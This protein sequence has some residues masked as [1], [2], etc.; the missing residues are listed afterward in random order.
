MKPSVHTFGD[1]KVTRAYICHESYPKHP[2]CYIMWD[3]EYYGNKMRV[4]ND[5]VNMEFWDSIT[6]DNIIAKNELVSITPEFV[7]GNQVGIDL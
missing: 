4:V 3:S 1:F 7:V 5:K 6:L 2:E